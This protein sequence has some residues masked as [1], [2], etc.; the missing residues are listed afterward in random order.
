MRLSHK[1]QPQ[2]K[3]KTTP[4]SPLDE[5]LINKLASDR[6]RKAGLK[7]RMNG[8]RRGI[9]PTTSERDYTADEIEFMTAMQR[10]IE[11]SGNKFPLT[12]SP[13]VVLEVIRSLGYT[14]SEEL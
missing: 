9:D 6:A 4:V 7:S 11:Q 10:H 1:T 3:K 2:Q 14:M 12:D 13:G 8:R 5:S